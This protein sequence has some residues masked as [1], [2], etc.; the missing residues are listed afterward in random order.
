MNTFSTYLKRALIVVA[1]LGAA[2]WIQVDV[3]ATTVNALGS[4]TAVTAPGSDLGW[5]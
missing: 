1:A 5:G 4:G 2:A 3:S